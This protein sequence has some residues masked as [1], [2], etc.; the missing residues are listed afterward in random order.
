MNKTSLIIA[1]VLTLIVTETVLKSAPPPRRTYP[2]NRPEPPKF[3]AN[4]IR[5]T[6][7]TAHVIRPCIDPP[8]RVSPTWWAL[9]NY[10][11]TLA[12]REQITG[13]K[14]PPQFPPYHTPRLV[15]TN[16]W[17]TNRFSAPLF[18]LR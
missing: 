4:V 12:P 14:V 9:H 17:N 3:L 10:Q 2:I 7:F 18:P 1:S 15:L 13:S 6:E 8:I 5:R 11:Q 16:Y